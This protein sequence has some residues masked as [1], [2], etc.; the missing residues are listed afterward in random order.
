M[1]RGAASLMIGALHRSYLTLRTVGAWLQRRFTPAGG[2]VLAGLALT[3]TASD[4]D[5]MGL[6][7]FVLLFAMLSAAWLVTPFFRARF[8][9]E[10]QAPRFVTAGEPFTLRVR[11][12]NLSNRAQRGLE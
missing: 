8:A 1:Q 4:P 9:V 3:A 10:R 2:F 6:S 7:A 5:T 11:V 12:E